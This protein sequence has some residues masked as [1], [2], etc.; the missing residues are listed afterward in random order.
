M[1]QIN[2]FVKSFQFIFQQ[3]TGGCVTPERAVLQGICSIFIYV[4]MIEWNDDRKN[5]EEGWWI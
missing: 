2:S 3:G 5:Y 1:V 4:V